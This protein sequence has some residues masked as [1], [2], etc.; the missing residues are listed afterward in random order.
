MYILLKIFYIYR[1]SVLNSYNSVDIEINIACVF[2]LQRTIPESWK[3]QINWEDWIKSEF[4]KVSDHAF[5]R[6]EHSSNTQNSNWYFFKIFYVYSSIKNKINDIDIVLFIYVWK[7]KWSS[8]EITIF[9]YKKQWSS[10]LFNSFQHLW[11]FT[12]TGNNEKTLHNETRC[13]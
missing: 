2:E 11:Y 5:Q 4:W 10:Q 6:D 3:C 13:I 1:E 9:E 12:K 7:Q 8:H